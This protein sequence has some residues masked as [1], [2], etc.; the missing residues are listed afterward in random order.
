M[1]IKQDRVG[2]RIRQILSELLL[3]EVS[4]PRL[5]GVTVTEVEL[6]PELAYAQVYVNALGDESRH[7]E[8]MAGLERAKGFL[9][10]EVGSRVRLRKT[11]EL[12]FHWDERLERGERINR[13]LSTLH[14]PPP[15]DDE[16]QP[17]PTRRSLEDELGMDEAFDPD[18]HDSMD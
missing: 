4:D 14:I 7:D 2:G 8:V 6:D 16:P 17:T 18:E 5:H 15:S 11:P 13:L 3:R 10:R 1:S 9:R 12:R